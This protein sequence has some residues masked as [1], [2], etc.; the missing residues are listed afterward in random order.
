[1]KLTDKQRRFCDEYLV[2][3]NAT[4]AAIRAGYPAK[5]ANKVGS[6]LLGNTRLSEYIQ[7]KQ[8]ATAKKLDISRERVLSEL[9]NIGFAKIT[10]FLEIVEEEVVSNPLS[11]GQPVPDGYKEIVHKYKRVDI[12][13]TLKVTPEAVPA[14]ASVKQGKDGIEIKVHDKVKALEAICKMQGYNAPDKIDLSGTITVKRPV[15]KNAG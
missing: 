10:D 7:S 15:R 6:Q 13:E 2:D 1:M 3:M 5:T 4:Q 9:A 12:F 14:I 8:N 11:E